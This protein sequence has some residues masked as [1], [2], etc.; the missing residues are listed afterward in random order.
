VKWLAA[1]AQIAIA[2]PLKRAKLITYVEFVPTFEIS[3]VCQRA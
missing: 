1:I 2:M 3:I